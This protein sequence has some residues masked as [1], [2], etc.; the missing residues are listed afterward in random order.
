[1]IAVGRSSLCGSERFSEGGRRC[2]NV[3]DEGMEQVGHL[4]HLTSLD[5]SMVF[6]ATGAPPPPAKRPSNC[7]R[8]DDHEDS[9]KAEAARGGGTAT[10]W[11]VAAVV[12]ESAWQVSRAGMTCAFPAVQRRAWHPCCS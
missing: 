6:N 11:P 7:L 2:E 9:L 1:M 3:V 4:R 12:H 5:L 8:S 10:G